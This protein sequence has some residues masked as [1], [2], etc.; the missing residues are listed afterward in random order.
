[1]TFKP[2]FPIP[3]GNHGGLV[4][5]DCGDRLYL[6]KAPDF[7]HRI[8]TDDQNAHISKFVRATRLA[9]QRLTEYIRALSPQALLAVE[10]VLRV[11]I[12]LP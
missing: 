1:M 11:Q 7:S 12:D 8:L 4:V 10:Q 6:I 3:R 2:G 9:K 5:R